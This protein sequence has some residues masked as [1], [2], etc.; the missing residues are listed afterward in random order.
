MSNWDT[1]YTDRNKWDGG[2]TGLTASTGR[3]S[4]GL[5]TAAATAATGDFA[6]AAQGTT[7]DAALP[8]AAGS[9]NKLTDTL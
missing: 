9:G 3:T 7:A 4:L 8:K 5:G 1:A 2:S 6:T